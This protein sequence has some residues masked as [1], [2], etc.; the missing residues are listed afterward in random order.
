MNDEVRYNPSTGE[1]LTCAEQARRLVLLARFESNRF[2]R[3]RLLREAGEFALAAVQ[4]AHQR[5]VKAVPNGVHKGESTT[6]LYE[7]LVKFAGDENLFAHISLRLYER[8]LGR[9]GIPEEADPLLG[10]YFH[11]INRQRLERHMTAFLIQATGG[12]TRYSGRSMT[13]AHA[14]VGVTEEAWS[15][16]LFHVKQTLREYR[17]PEEYIDEIGDVIA[18]IRASIVTR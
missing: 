18:P 13:V 8:V 16:L 11:G 15:R 10:P 9:A 2:K 4:E 6:T 14:G 3:G 12:N 17:T 7:R 5:E 1:R